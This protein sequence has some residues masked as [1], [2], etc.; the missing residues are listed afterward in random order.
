MFCKNLN[1][2]G[3]YSQNLMIFLLIKADF[4]KKIVKKRNKTYLKCSISKFLT[5][6]E[7]MNRLFYIFN[8]LIFVQIHSIHSNR[9][10]YERNTDVPGPSRHTLFWRKPVLFRKW[11]QGKI[12]MRLFFF[13]FLTFIKQKRKNQ[14]SG[15]KNL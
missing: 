6:S 9:W 3:Q 7:C 5:K 4:F 12:G 10:K 8:L 15:N 13:F 2:G 1:A 14:G 11:Q